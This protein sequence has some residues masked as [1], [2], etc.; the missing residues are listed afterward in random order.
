MPEIILIGGGVCNEGDPLLLPS[1]KKALS[2]NPI[3]PRG[4]ATAESNWP[5][6]EMMPELSEPL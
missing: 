6:W 5:V 2:L 4:S 1:G 3:L